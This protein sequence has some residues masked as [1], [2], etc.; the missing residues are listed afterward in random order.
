MSDIDVSKLKGLR[1]AN[2][3]VN[4]LLKHLDEIR[5]MLSD[6]PFDILAINESKIDPSISNSEISIQHY[7]IVRLDRNRYGGGV[8]LYIKN[9]IPY[10]ERQD[11]V[12]DDLEM[13]CIEVN[14]KHSKPFL[15]GTWYRPPSSNPQIN[16]EFQFHQITVENV[17]LALM[18]LIK[19]KQIHWFG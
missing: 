14:R 6:Y 8:V 12:S 13:I 3:N 19:D 17:A 15:I 4:S 1:I 16:A 9:N 5:T 18:N 7:S 11:L 2:L 10:V